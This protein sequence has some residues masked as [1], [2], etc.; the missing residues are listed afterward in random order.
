VRQAVEEM[1][2]AVEAAGM[3]LEVRSEPATLALD[4]DRIL[5]VLT[6]LIDNAV[7]FSAPGSVILVEQSRHDQG[8]ACRVR[9]PG[10]GIPAD[11]LPR[12]FERFVQV[13]PGDQLLGGAGLGLAIC[14][15]IVAQHGGQIMAESTAGEG[16]TFTFTLPGAPA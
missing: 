13:Q 3:R 16:S 2:P 4:G 15:A 9:D 10:R 6:N 11:V 12:I 5:Q 8:V 1:Q 7:K 14:Q